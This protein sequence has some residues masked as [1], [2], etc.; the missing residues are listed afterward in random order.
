MGDS[1]GEAYVIVSGPPGGE[2]L[3]TQSTIVRDHA[4]PLGEASCVIG[5]AALAVEDNDPARASR[6]LASVA[7]AGFFP[8]RTPLDVA[9][10]QRCLAAAR[11]AL[12]PEA[13]RRFRTEGTAISVSEALD[14]ELQR[15]VGGVHPD[16][17]TE[18][19]QDGNGP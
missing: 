1:I 13:A 10:Y 3:R 6:L 17:K 11:R 18:H 9:A 19:T 12:D 15:L 5:F 4:I 16:R 14:G 8:F 2:H 7:A